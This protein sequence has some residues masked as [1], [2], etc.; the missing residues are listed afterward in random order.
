MSRFEQ[1]RGWQSEQEKAVSQYWDDLRDAVSRIWVGFAEY[2]ELPQSEYEA[3]NGE[4]HHY[5]KLARVENGKYIESNTHELVG[6]NSALEFCLGLTVDASVGT[7][8]K[9]TVYT[10]LKIKK[11]PGGYLVTSD[12][13]SFSVKASGTSNT[14][15]FDP[16]YEE[17]FQLLRKH[18]TLRP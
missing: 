16:V 15:D 13:H 18:F 14:A 10:Q 12:Q 8:P 4:R 11:E 2:L 5:V 1:L 7:F 3:L 17:V 6:K 9:T